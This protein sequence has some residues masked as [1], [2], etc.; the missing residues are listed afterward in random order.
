MSRVFAVRF[1]RALVSIPLFWAAAVSAQLK[2]FV[3]L[4]EPSDFPLKITDSW[5]LAPD[6]DIIFADARTDVSMPWFPALLTAPVKP[7]ASAPYTPPPVTPAF[8]KGVHNYRVRVPIA[9][10]TVVYGG[11]ES[12]TPLALNGTTIRLWNKDNYMYASFNGRQLYQSHPW[13]LALQ[14]D[15]SAYGLMFCTTWM[16][17]IQ[18]TNSEVIFTTV[19]Q[20]P[21]VIT[22]SGTTPQDIILKLAKL[23]G[24]MPLPPLWSLGYQ[25]SKYSYETAVIVAQIADTFRAKKIPCDVIWVDIDYMDGYRVFT[26]NKTT[27][28]NPKALNDYL[29][30]LNFKSVW[31]IDPGVKYQPNGTYAVYESGSLYNLWILDSQKQPYIGTVWPGQSVYPDFTMPRTG[32]WWAGLYQSFLSNGID[33]VWNDMNEPANFGGPDGSLPTNCFH[34]GGGKIPEGPHLQFHNAYGMLMAAGTRSGILQARPNLRPFILSRDNFLGGQRIAAAWTGDNQS[35]PQNMMAAIPMTLNLGLSGQPFNG[36]D[37]GGFVGNP[38]PDFMARWMG[39]GVFFP[40]VRAHSDK[41]SISKEP[42]A[43]GPAAEISMRT[44]IKRRYAL[45]PYIYTVFSES[46]VTGLPVMRPLFFTDPADPALRLEDRAFLLG[47]DIFVKPDFSPYGVDPASVAVPKGAWPEIRVAGENPD[48]D[49]CQARIYQRPGSIVPCVSADG[50]Q[51][52]VDVNPST[53]ILSVIPDSSGKASGSMY[54]DSGNGFEYLKGSFARMKYTVEQTATQIMFR[55]ERAE[56]MMF[57]PTKIYKLRIYQADGTFL[58]LE[59]LSEKADFPL[60]IL[61]S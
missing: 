58:E 52:T 61:K 35:T 18:T 11:G 46:A 42:W 8:S 24:Y 55:A 53:L 10:G 27:F 23:T 3:W 36:P 25:Q 14:P 12:L 59:A 39:F 49:P 37:L 60:P 4:D 38:T 19:G 40:F 13:V 43:F 15:G 1:F 48:Q 57:A 33:G 44:S 21:P 47:P 7:A 16:S 22:V 17:Q 5:A 32:T 9:P 28:P 6:C 51:S 45:M 29:H 34:R 54:W 2:E 20:L 31:M 50:I 26:F 56:G 30:K 41:S